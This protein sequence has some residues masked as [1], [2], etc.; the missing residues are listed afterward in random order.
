V[1]K[2]DYVSKKILD[3][4]NGRTTW[5][6]TATIDFHLYTATPTHTTAGTEVTG[7]SYVVVNV[8]NDSTTWAA[9]ITAT[10]SSATTIIVIG[11]W[12]TATANWGTVTSAAIS[13]GGNSNLTYYGNLTASR[14]VN[15]GDSVRFAIG[16]VVMTES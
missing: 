6:P 2:A 10:P 14:A 11:P 16:G 7:G 15:T 3:H 5:T 12:P 1:G 8:A 4:G 13:E 9:A